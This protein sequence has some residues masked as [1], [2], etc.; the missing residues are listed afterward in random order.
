MKKLLRSQP[1]FS[2]IFAV[3]ILGA[4]ACS[5][6]LPDP[7]DPPSIDPGSG[8]LPEFGLPDLIPSGRLSMEGPG[9]QNCIFEYGDLISEVCVRN[10]GNAAAGVFTLDAGPG[11][12]WS[13]PGL[14]AGGSICYE[15]KIGLSG[16]TVTADPDNVVPESD[17]TNNTTIVPIPT[18]PLICTP[19]PELTEANFSYQGVTFNYDSSLAAAI[20]PEFIPVDTEGPESWWTPEHVFISLEGYPL[21]DTFQRPAIRIFPVEPYMTLN[22]EAAAE[23]TALQGLLAARHMEPESIP[24]LPIVNAAQFMQAQVSYLDFQNGSGVRFLTQYGQDAW[25]INN[26]S[27]FYSFQGLTADG[28]YYISAILPAS[29]PSLL[30]PDPEPLSDED[31][32][33][34]APYVTEIENQLNELSAESFFPSLL[35]LDDMIRSIQVMRIGD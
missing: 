15:S 6:L 7:A 35:L 8:D 17:E 33:N 24:F 12:I 2:L 1:Q 34:F 19:T 32:L 9:G 30:P 4:L 16:S 27:M 31:Y 26:G 25:P 3:L 13:I 14:E 28:G 23:I 11:A 21:V 10:R 22:V 18:P 29:H 20:T 5:T